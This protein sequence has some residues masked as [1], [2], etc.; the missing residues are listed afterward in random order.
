MENGNVV[1]GKVQS[2]PIIDRTLTKEGR[3][4][5]AKATGEKLTELTTRLD[6]ID[7]H[8]AENVKYKNTSSRLIA[9]NMQQAVDEMVSRKPDGS[10]EGNGS[11]AARVINVGG[12]G[13]WL[14]VCCGSYMIGFISQN[15]AVFFSTKD[16]TIKCFPVAQA[17]YVSG[18][19]HLSSN[20]AYLNADG[21]TYHYQ[22]L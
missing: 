15:G 13:G 10:Y 12:N 5:D 16:S 20:D 6:D 19:L 3:C 8:F 4:A 17:K 7:P 11:T 18:V 21:Y 9:T 14:G 1:S 2:F 22:V